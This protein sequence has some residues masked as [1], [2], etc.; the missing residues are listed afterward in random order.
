MAKSM[1]QDFVR[2]SVGNQTRTLVTA[3]STAI[4]VIV[5][6]LI[7][8]A[9]V[10]PK[11][12]E[13]S[14]TEVHL[15]LPASGPGLKE[16]SKVLLRGA[17]VGVVTSIDSTDPY[18]VQ[19]DIALDEA[20]AAT[21]TDTF[22]VDF[23][24]ANYFGTTAVNLIAK[25]G[26]GSISDGETIARDSA[27]DFTMS[28]MLEHGSIVVDGSLTRDVISSLNKVTKYAS[29]LSPLIETMIV[30]SDNVSRTQKQLPSTLL[31]KLNDITA[32]FPN[33]NVEALG[34]LDAI[35]NA[36]FNRMPDGSRGADKAYHDLM[37]RSLTVASDGL[38][39]AIGTLLASHATELT[40]VVTSI[41]YLA[42]EVPGVMGDASNMTKLQKAVEGLERSFKGPKGKQTLQL[43]IL[44]DSVPGLSQTMTAMGVKPGATSQPDK[45]SRPSDRPTK[46]K[47][48]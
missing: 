37:N 30:V 34:A 39:G 21:L 38:F 25:P 16:K 3:G 6:A 33:A 8:T 15:V 17:E 7:V 48:N 40:P 32:V 5:L 13:P 10:Y 2:G 1:H 35:T 12:T 43:R 22:D 28:T 47:E 27:P 4:I 36:Q 24:P 19:V 45:N 44:L 29:G 42:D 31:G 20:A 46:K 14:G 23:R 26:G 11:A 18:S 9:V 41:K